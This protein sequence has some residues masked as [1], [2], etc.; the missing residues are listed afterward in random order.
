MLS[1]HRRCSPPVPFGI[2]RVAGLEQLLRGGCLEKLVLVEALA[3][4]LMS[5]GIG[6][7]EHSSFVIQSLHTGI[8]IQ[9]NDV[10]CDI[11]AMCRQQVMATSG[12]RG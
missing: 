1:W 7:Y 9:D 12:T 6:G 3:A 11:A 8:G 4:G 10:A 5:E 2:G